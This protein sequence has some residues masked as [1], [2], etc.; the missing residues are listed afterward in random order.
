MNLQN[1]EMSTIDF[2][3]GEQAKAEAG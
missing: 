1:H 2:S 3:L